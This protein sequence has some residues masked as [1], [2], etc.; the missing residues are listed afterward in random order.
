V[1]PQ[2]SVSSLAVDSRWLSASAAVRLGGACFEGFSC[3]R[4]ASRGQRSFGARPGTML[5]FTVFFGTS[6][7]K[8]CWYYHQ[9]RALRWPDPYDPSIKPY[10]VSLDR[11]DGYI[12]TISAPHDIVMMS[13]D[14]VYI[15]SEVPTPDG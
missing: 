9:F 13:R 3:R 7:G 15:V 8:R 5:A 2:K 14:F 4:C 6:A 11:R 10:I 1:S 12:V